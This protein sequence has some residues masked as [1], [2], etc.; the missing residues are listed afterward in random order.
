MLPSLRDPKARSEYPKELPVWMELDYFW[1]PRFL[2]TWRRGLS[3]GTL[4]LGIVAIVLLLGGSRDR[5]AFQAAPVSRVHRPID[6]DCH[7]CHTRRFETI[8]RVWQDH[9]GA[10][11]VP[12]AACQKCHPGSV[13]HSRELGA[14]ACVRCHREHRGDELLAQLNEQTCTSCHADLKAHTATGAP[15]DVDRP[16]RDVRSFTA[17]GH[18]EF[19]IWESGAKDEGTIR[20]NH[21]KHLQPGGIPVGE[22]RTLTKLACDR[23]HELDDDGR[24]MQ[25]IDYDR[26]CRDCHPLNA[27]L[28]GDFHDERLHRDFARFV[29]TPLRHPARGEGANSVR[30]ELR[31][32]FTAFARHH[33]EVLGVGPNPAPARPLP[34][35]RPMAEDAPAEKEWTW[36]AEQLRRA[37]PPLFD[38]KA[39]CLFCHTE[40]SK[41]SERTDGL[42]EYAAPAI[43]DRWLPHSVFDHETHRALD[44]EQCH[45]GARQNELSSTVLMPRIGTCQQCHKP[46]QVA[47]RA[48]CTECHIYHNPKSERSWNGTLTIEQLFNPETA[49][50]RRAGSR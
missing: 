19:A 23:C 45:A 11:S 14:T 12:D 35:R 3:W 38:S 10:Y 37:E 5:R 34:G 1:R 2:R 33:P 13:H 40:T 43:K 24:Y 32:R 49:T 16:I 50:S 29:E 26:H 9:V 4:A 47:A 21:R 39:G 31:E 15:S 7:A 25:P 8:K 27:G 22:Q 36:V 28:T 30:A 17:Q 41:A 6:D 42:P 44:C 20:F 48:G 46:D 18:P